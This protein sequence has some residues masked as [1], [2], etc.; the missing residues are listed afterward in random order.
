MSEPL[1]VE[2]A[3]AGDR[4]AILEVMRPANMHA[5]PSPEM[6]EL[7]PT[8]FFVARLGGKVVGAGGYKLLGPERAKTTLLAVLPEY[9][10]MGIGA[11]LQEARL[12]AMHRAGVTTVVTN[13]DRPPTIEW[14]KR[15]FGYREVG[16]LK[17]LVPFG[18][19]NVDEWTTLEL[20][21]AGYMRRAQRQ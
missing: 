21:L 11:A 16:K 2:R 10:R 13:A 4:R 7:D 3:R 1:R 15:R 18:D 14:Y 6:E 12:R 20:D 17:K 19:P 8:C 5:V 9:G